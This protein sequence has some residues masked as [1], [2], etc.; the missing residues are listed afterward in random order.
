MANKLGISVK[1]LMNRL[2]DMVAGMPAAAQEVVDKTAYRIEARAK[3]TVPVVTGTL[4][5]SIHTLTP[6]TTDVANTAPSK[7]AVPLGPNPPAGQAYVGV[8]VKYG[9]V[10]EFGQGKR[11]PKPYLIPALEAEMPAFREEMKKVV[12]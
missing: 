10:V 4:R 5:R 8:G 9:K 7:V 12:K 1:V 6:T 11:P 3:K 2:P